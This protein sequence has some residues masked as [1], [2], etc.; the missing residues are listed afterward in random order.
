MSNP[1]ERGIMTKRAGIVTA[2]ATLA[3]SAMAC[4]DAPGEASSA[5]GGELTRS[6]DASCRGLMYSIPDGI[7]VKRRDA[8]CPVLVVDGVSVAGVAASQYAANIIARNYQWTFG[9]TDDQALENMFGSY[10]PAA[11]QPGS[12]YCVYETPV[13]HAPIPT[14]DEEAAATSEQ[15]ASFVSVDVLCS[16]AANRPGSHPCG[17]CKE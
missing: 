15:G 4:G 1:D 12:P 10:W 5:N 13:G 9:L 14:S 7:V 6:I 17:S 16:P 2:A 8:R 11:G 3:I